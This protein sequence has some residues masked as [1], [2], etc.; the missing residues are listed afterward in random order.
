MIMKYNR[1]GITRL[2]FEFKN[3]VIKVPNYSYSWEHFLKGLIANIQES[4]TWKYNKHKPEI[5]NILCPVVWTSW[6]GWI[7]I[8]KKADVK[9]H[10]DYVRSLPKEGNIY[11]KWETCGFIGDNKADNYGFIG[12]RI[13]KIDYGQS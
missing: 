13:V 6:G 5:T 10:I 11:S 7:L 3:V 8:M 9:K 4:T 2:V 1:T 12:E